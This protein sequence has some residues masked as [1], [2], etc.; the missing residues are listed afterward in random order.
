VEGLLHADDSAIFRKIV[1][2]RRWSADTSIV[3]S[4]KRLQNNEHLI[5]AT[6]FAAMSNEIPTAGLSYWA[7]CRW[8]IALAA[9]K[10]KPK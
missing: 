4:V 9:N 7:G 10:G 8:R 2:I 1:I 5:V 6:H 3:Q